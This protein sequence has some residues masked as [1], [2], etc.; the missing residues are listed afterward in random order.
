MNPTGCSLA[1]AL[2]KPKYNRFLVPIWI[3][4]FETTPMYVQHVLPPKI[5]MLWYFDLIDA[6]VST[7]C[8]KQPVQTWSLPSCQSLEIF[9]FW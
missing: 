5:N 6:R 2:I 7:S 4:G 1:E 8:K 9:S 3:P